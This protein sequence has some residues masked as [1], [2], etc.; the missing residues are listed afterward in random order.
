MSEKVKGLAVAKMQLRAISMMPANLL[1]KQS[2]AVYLSSIKAQMLQAQT[3]QPLTV[4]EIM[5]KAELLAPLIWKV[6]AKIGISKEEYKAL[7]A[8]VVNEHGKH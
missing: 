2:K 5:A 7:A 1:Q 4:D 6:Y 8:E 3:A